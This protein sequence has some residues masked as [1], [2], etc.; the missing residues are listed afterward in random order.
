MM[1]PYE[2]VSKTF[3]TINFERQH[4]R[5]AS[6]RFNEPYFLRLHSMNRKLM[7]ENILVMVLA[8]W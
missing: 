3:C 8:Q 7:D 2:Y 5:Q 4:I 6:N 1:L